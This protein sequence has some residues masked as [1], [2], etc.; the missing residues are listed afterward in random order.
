MPELILAAGVRFRL[1]SGLRFRGRLCFPI[2]ESG[3]LKVND[4]TTNHAGGV[5]GSFDLFYAPTLL[6]ILRMGPV[7]GVEAWG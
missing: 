4:S 5:L 3:L 7:K 2:S 6:F 1:S